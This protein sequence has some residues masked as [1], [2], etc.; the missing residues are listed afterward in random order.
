MT[1]VAKK[2]LIM[3]KSR[4]ANELKSCEALTFYFFGRQAFIPFRRVHET[5]VHHST[6]NNV[7]RRRS[8]L[9]GHTL[10]RSSTISDPRRDSIDKQGRPFRLGKENM[11]N[12]V[13]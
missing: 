2:D 10:R 8:I 7:K 3:Q 5:Y 9:L 6:V 1:R 4:K 12:C 11:F 13:K